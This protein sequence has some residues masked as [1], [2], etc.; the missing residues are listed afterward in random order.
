MSKPSERT[1]RRRLKELRQLID[2]NPDP[3]VQRIAYGMESAIIW[4]TKDTVGWEP[5]AQLAMALAKILH[6]E[7]R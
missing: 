4:A 3:C 6:K 5:P 1:I 7:L 2:G